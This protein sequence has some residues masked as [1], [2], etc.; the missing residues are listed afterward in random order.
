MLKGKIPKKGREL[1]K[2]QKRIRVRIRNMSLQS[3]VLG[4][5]VESLR[6]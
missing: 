3:R 4:S 2:L 1:E 5:I 6:C